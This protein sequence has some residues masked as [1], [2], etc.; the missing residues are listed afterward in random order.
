MAPAVGVGVGLGLTASG[1]SIWTPAELGASLLGWWRAETDN[2]TIETGVSSWTDLSGNGE[3]LANANTDQQP[4]FSATG[5][6]NGRGYLEFDGTDDQLNTSVNLTGT[7]HYFMVVLPRISGSGIDTF[8]VG[9]AGNAQKI[10]LSAANTLKA[11][12]A[13]GANELTAAIDED[14]WHGIEVLFSATGSIIID[15]GT[16]AT[17]D[18]AAGAVTGL[19]LGTNHTSTQPT[20]CRI[21]EMF[22][23]SGAL[24]GDDLAGAQAYIAV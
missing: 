10:Q 20:N 16:P 11:V 14:V 3:H 6:P 1:V 13:G 5:G 17:G 2:V 23:V 15:G 19:R 7:L 12:G 21:A 8:V 4:A 22:I 9:G 18:I 24:T